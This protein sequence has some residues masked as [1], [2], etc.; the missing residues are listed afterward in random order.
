M[1]SGNIARLVWRGQAG[2]NG[3]GYLKAL[4]QLRANSDETRLRIGDV[5]AAR[6][7]LTAFPLRFEMA[8]FCIT[9]TRFYVK[10]VVL[11]SEGEMTRLQANADPFQ[12]ELKCSFFSKVRVVGKSVRT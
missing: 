11:G 7:M 10:D 5:E 4:D 6:V 9:N 2:C 1:K 8:F 12:T 3:V